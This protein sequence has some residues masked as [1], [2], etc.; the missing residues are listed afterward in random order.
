M[1]NKTTALWPAFILS[2]VAIAAITCFPARAAIFSVRVNAASTNIP[3]AFSTSSASRVL[4]GVR[5]LRAILIDNRTSSEIAIN[6]QATSAAAPSD[7]A[8]TNMYV[9]GTSQIAIDDAFLNDTCYI[10]SMTGSAITTGTF[11]I[12]AVGG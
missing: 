11:V 3:T 2:A 12:M 1:K 4:T 6:C 8:F 9:A 10:R 5:N 7:T